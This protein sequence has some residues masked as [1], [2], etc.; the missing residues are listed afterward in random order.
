[1]HQIT[2]ICLYHTEGNLWLYLSFSSKLFHVV[3]VTLFM[4]FFKNAFIFTKQRHFLFLFLQCATCRMPIKDYS[5]VFYSAENE[6]MVHHSF[7]LCDLETQQH[8]AGTNAKKRATS[9]I[10]FTVALLIYQISALMR[11]RGTQKLQMKL[12]DAWL[13]SETKGEERMRCA[14]ALV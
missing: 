12:T 13:G 2:F 11:C 8:S 5:V 14:T 1:M 9:D 10:H 7:S 6:V 4:L 3:F